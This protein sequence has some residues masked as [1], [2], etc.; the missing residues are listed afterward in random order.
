MPDLPNRTRLEQELTGDLARILDRARKSALKNPQAELQTE[1]QESEDKL[2]A[3]LIAVYLL[4]L[5]GMVKWG[6]WSEKRRQEQ[7]RRYATARARQVMQDSFYR[8]RDAMRQSAS[9]AMT[10]VSVGVSPAVAVAEYGDDLADIFN[11]TRAE[12]IAITEIT[13]ANSVA[14]IELIDWINEWL[15]RGS[16]L[17][18]GPLSQPPADDGTIEPQPPGS[19]IAAYWQTEKDEKVCPICSPLHNQ[20]EQPGVIGN[21]TELFPLGPPAHPRC[22]CFIVWILD[23][24]K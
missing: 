1:Q 21:W 11:K 6:S 24:E 5:G 9:R 23:A 7:A 3:F 2:A 13:A 18:D 19:Q 17:P 22:R 12:I 8:M 10:A 16:G 4:S 20:L 14:E 15:T